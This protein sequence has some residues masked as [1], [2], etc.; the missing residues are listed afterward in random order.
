MPITNERLAMDSA[1]EVDRFGKMFV[2][3][4]RISKATINDYYGE[5][6]PGHEKLRLQKS[7][8][9]AFYGPPRSL[10][11]PPPVF[12]VFPCCWGIPRTITPGHWLNWRSAR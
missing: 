12:T 10:S 11:S 8:S 1:R 6:I 7:G 2:R 9:I 4:N 3:D 5:E